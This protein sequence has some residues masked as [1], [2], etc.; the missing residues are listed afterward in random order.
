MEAWT[1]DRYSRPRLAQDTD[2]RVRGCTIELVRGGYQRAITVDAADAVDE[3]VSGIEGLRDP[4]HGLWSDIAASGPKDAWRHLA[5][6]LDE[7]SFVEDADDNG[8]VSASND[9]LG[10]IAAIVD[11]A[12]LHVCERTPRHLRPG[13][14]AQAAQW[15]RLVETDSLDARG[16][17]TDPN[18]Y[19][20]I[21]RLSIARLRRSHPAAFE[22]ATGM[23]SV[24]AGLPDPTP[25]SPATCFADDQLRAHMNALADFFCR[26]FG[27]MA[28]RRCTAQR[29]SK[30][31]IS[32][33][34]FAR[35]A[36]H[37]MRAHAQSLGRGRFA[38]ALEDLPSAHHP[39]AIGC[40]V[41]EYHVTRR[42]VE[43]I[44]PLMH[45]D[46]NAPL[47]ALVFRY[48][49]EEVGHESFERATC[50]S[51][52]IGADQ[53][54]CA[55]PL[56]LHL[57]FVDVFA[58]LAALHPVAFLA[59]V[60]ITE[61]L[62]GEASPINARLDEFVPVGAA[63]RE[64]FHRHEKLNLELNHASI[65]RL[66]LDMVTA[67]PPDIQ[68]Q[69]LDGLALAF[70][71]NFRAWEGLVEFYGSQHELRLPKAFPPPVATA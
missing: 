50:A 48:F 27:P 57:A 28:G 17:W 3:M 22:A 2:I 29:A 46:L 61:G 68:Q 18:L 13:L 43:M 62:L 15:L 5:Q 71:L 45:C 14:A 63:E 56:P 32:G 54:D 11:E 38:E 10:A 7:W 64:V 51:L 9:A 12:A 40:H 49:A 23:L 44:T 1:L 67:I 55:C 70:E 65:A 37:A 66:A 19:R 69:A 39:L 52:G 20:A 42:F 36:E 60:P 58:M 6:K 8:A 30:R 41:E 26:S 53:L 24:L 34:A 4:A 21:G 31:P 16:G 59:A 47:R 25:P 35:M 33:T